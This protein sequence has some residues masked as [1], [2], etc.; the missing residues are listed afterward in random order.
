MLPGVKHFERK[1]DILLGFRVVYGDAVFVTVTPNRRNSALLMYLSRTRMNET[2]FLDGNSST[3]YR[4]Q[5]CG[6]DV[7][8]FI[9][10]QSIH[11]DNDGRK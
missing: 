10:E 1:L 8:N 5:H 2:C 3:Q 4:R 11:G 9:S 6:M 7:P